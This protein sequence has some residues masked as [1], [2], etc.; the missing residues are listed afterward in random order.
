MR[1]KIIALNLTKR[2]FFD[3][4]SYDTYKKFINPNDKDTSIWSAFWSDDL[5]KFIFS[6]KGSNE[7]IAKEKGL[8]HN[9]STL[10]ANWYS[11]DIMRNHEAGGVS[12]SPYG[13]P[14][15]S[16][17][18]SQ[19]Q[20][21]EGMIDQ[22]FL[23]KFP[24]IQYYQLNYE[25]ELP[26]NLIANATTW[27]NNLTIKPISNDEMFGLTP[28]EDLP[29]IK[30]TKNSLIYDHNSEEVLSRFFKD[31]KRS[32]TGLLNAKTL[33]FVL[34]EGMAH[35]NL[36]KEKYLYAEDHDSLSPYWY[37]FNIISGKTNEEINVSP[38]SGKFGGIPIEVHREFEATIRHEFEKQFPN[39]LYYQ[40]NYERGINKEL[41]LIAAYQQENLTK[42]PL[43]NAE[44]MGDMVSDI[45][46]ESFHK[47]EQSSPIIGLLK[48]IKNIWPF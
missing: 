23:E 6:D 48:I 12:I 30:I 16:V 33:Q 39:I 2:L 4:E 7:Q 10:R 5:N 13:Y 27:N 26:N 47:K 31:T 17:P 24:L 20:K 8:L 44:F 9:K 1:N 28:T 29:E 45:I 42:K 34:G 21:F 41:L 11:F 35:V 14:F 46:S 18:I 15:K 19:N 36:A 22:L 32:L 43:N 40:D 38:I 25:R 3:Q 37:G